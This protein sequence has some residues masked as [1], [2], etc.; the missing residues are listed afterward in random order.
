[1]KTALITGGARGIGRAIA[2]DLASR[3]WNIALSYRT[4]ESEAA[5]TR[6]DAETHGVKTFAMRADASDPA[7]CEELF[8]RVRE[9][10]G[11][12]DALIHA[13]GP[14]HRVDLLKETPEGWRNMLANNLDS[15]FYCARLAAPAMIEKK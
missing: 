5:Q 2:L 11:S 12:P 3:G 14:Y 9:A 7:T 6:A 15:F 8:K 1:M 10:V 4:S 13:A